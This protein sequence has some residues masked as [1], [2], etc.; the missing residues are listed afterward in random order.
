MRNILYKYDLKDNFVYKCICNYTDPIT[1]KSYVKGD[2]VM[3]DDV[4]DINELNKP[5]FNMIGGLGVTHDYDS[6]GNIVELYRRPVEIG[7]V[8]NVK[9]L[10]IPKKNVVVL[11]ILEDE[12]LAVVYPYNIGYIPLGPLVREEKVGWMGINY[13]F[14]FNPEY[15]VIEV[16]KEEL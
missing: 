14:N 11:D 4:D 16:N 10:H 2:I 12:E 9:F 1:E 15:K 13:H 3:G 7:D 5:F 8:Y 6:D